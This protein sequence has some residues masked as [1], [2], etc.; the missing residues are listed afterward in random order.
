MPLAQIQTMPRFIPRL[1]FNMLPKLRYIFL[2]LFLYLV[3][4]LATLPAQHVY[5][6]WKQY[7]GKQ[8]PVMLTDVEGTLWSGRAG[9]SRL[10]PQIVKAVQWRFHPLSLLLGRLELDWEVTVADGYTKGIA[11][12]NVMGLLYL[13]QLEGLVPMDYLAKAAKMEALRPAGSMGINLDRLEFKDQSIMSVNGNL[14]WHGAEVTLLKPMRL[15]D[16]KVKLET[17]SEGI[18]GILS[19]AG[20]PLQA[21]GLLSLDAE[22]G[23]QFNGTLMVRDPS[24]TD[25]ANALRSLGRPDSSGKYKI[26]QSGKLSQLRF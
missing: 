22:G 13:K 7:L 11:G 14:A 24:Q 23:Y 4:L 10:G 6:Y 12:I 20:G 26:K 9:E 8:T 15:G 21:E 25:L 1:R 2:A 5:T 17:D 19:D 16:F 18:K 3:F